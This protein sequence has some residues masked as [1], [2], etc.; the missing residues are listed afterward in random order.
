MSKVILKLNATGLKTSVCDYRA[1]LTMVQGYYSGTLSSKIIYGVALH[2]YFDT[3]YQERGH[4]GKARDAALKAFNR[5]MTHDK[6]AMHYSDSTHML[7]SAYDAWEFHISKDQEFQTIMLPDG[8]PATE[9]TFSIG[10]YYEDEYLRV[11]LEGTIDRLGKITGGVYAINDFKSTGTWDQIGYLKKYALAQQMRFYILAI[12]LMAESDPESVLGQIGKTD[13]GYCIDGIF[14]KPKPCDN[15]Y[16]RSEVFMVK[17]LPE[18]RE[19]LD[20][21]IQ[22][23]SRMLARVREGKKPLKTGIV[24]GGCEGKWG[25]CNFWNIC[26]SQDPAIADMLLARDFKQKPYNPLAHNEEV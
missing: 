9:V 25:M 7:A 14:I 8:K 20:S 12:K 22:D 23:L 18:F 26:K 24:N 10:G 17:D 1:W 2:K 5:P 13:I 21:K 19:S 4:I 6:K 15:V 16:K 3:M 11:D